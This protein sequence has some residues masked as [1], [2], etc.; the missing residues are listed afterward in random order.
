MGDNTERCFERAHKQQTSILKPNQV[1]R[2][3]EEAFGNSS[4][5]NQSLKNMTVSKL[6]VQKAIL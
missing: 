4:E 2:A 1:K 3:S 6:K 5:V